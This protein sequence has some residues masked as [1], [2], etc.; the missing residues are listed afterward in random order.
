MARS[1]HRDNRTVARFGKAKINMLVGVDWGGTKIEAI[2][3][4]DDGR[5]IAR[6]R[7]GPP[8]SDYAA[9]FAPVA[10]VVIK[11]EATARETGTVGVGIPGSLDPATGL[12]KGAS[13]T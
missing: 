3:I 13:S 1:R 5:T 12:A 6:L 11:V 9:G 2:A 8:R 4:A 7:E 10:S